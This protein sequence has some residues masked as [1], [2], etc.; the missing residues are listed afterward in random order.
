LRRAIDEDAAETLRQLA[1]GLKG[2]AATVGAC[3]MSE[4][5]D[6]LGKLAAAGHTSGAD[7]IH[8]ELVDALRDTAAAMNTYVKETIA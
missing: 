3:R 6:A 2:S 1:H 7:E 4:L 8:L 5:C